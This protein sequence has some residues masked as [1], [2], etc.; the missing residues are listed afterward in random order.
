MNPLATVAVAAVACWAAAD[1][2]LLPRGQ[3]LGVEVS[4]PVAR[5][6]RAAAVAV[7]LANWAYLL[8]C[9]R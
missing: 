2:A 4:P 6:L 3:V 7:F 8:A 9:G 1:L 5:G